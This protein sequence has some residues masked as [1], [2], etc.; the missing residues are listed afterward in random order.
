M[1]YLQGDI[2]PHEH[3]DRLFLM[4]HDKKLNEIIKVWTSKEQPYAKE[5]TKLQRN[6]MMGPTRSDKVF[7]GCDIL[8]G[9]GMN[10]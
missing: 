4:K 6:P 5:P 7:D 3:I 9:A 1:T 2:M 8:R 10:E